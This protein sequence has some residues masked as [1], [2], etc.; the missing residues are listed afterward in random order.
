MGIV[1]KYKIINLQF[2]FDELHKKDLSLL[3]SRH[4][5]INTSFFDNIKLLSVL[6]QGDQG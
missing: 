6:V 1:S 5:D 2:K 4:N 3:P